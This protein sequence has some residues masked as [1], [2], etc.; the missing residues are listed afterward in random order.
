MA[1]NVALAEL[2]GSDYLLFYSLLITD[3]RNP[4][5]DF[6]R[7]PILSA[8]PLLTLFLLKARFVIRTA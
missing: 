4:S 8:I 6:K 7:V 3:R 5:T 1:V 2:N